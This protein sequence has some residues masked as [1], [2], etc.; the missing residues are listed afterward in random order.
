MPTQDDIEQQQ[1]RLA[2]HRRTL[3]HL[4]HQQAQFSAGHVP[5]HVANGI[6]EA[7]A[8]RTG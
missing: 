1:Q 7:R 5:A 3:A 6:A 4:L 8:D 2:A